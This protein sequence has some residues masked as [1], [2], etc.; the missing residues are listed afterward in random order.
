[1]YKMRL[2]QLADNGAEFTN[3]LLTEHLTINA[4]RSSLSAQLPSHEVIVALFHFLTCGWSKY[5]G[6][7]TGCVIVINFND[8]NE[9]WACVFWYTW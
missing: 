3:Y 9:L 5:C 8:I 2:Y 1:M 7:M 4:L 6:F